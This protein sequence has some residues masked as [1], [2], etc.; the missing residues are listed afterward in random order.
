MSRD[1]FQWLACIANHNNHFQRNNCHKDLVQRNQMMTT[2]QWAL[3][4]GGQIAYVTVRITRV[5]RHASITPLR[6]VSTNSLQRAFLA[7]RTDIASNWLR[8][9]A[10]KAAT[11]TDVKSIQCKWF[12]SLWRTFRPSSREDLK[13]SVV[14]KWLGE[15]D[16]SNCSTNE[17]DELKSL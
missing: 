6:L 10:P 2:I 4:E 9:C 15:S 3:T 1:I 11:T 17:S 12:D 5:R 8:I 13:A 16:V 7:L 14:V